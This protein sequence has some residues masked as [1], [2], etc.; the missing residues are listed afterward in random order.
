MAKKNWIKG[1]IKH[2]GALHEQLGVPADKKIPSKKMAS[3]RAGNYG[4]LAEKRAHLAKTLGSFDQ[5]GTV[6]KTGDYKLEEGEEVHSHSEG[7]GECRIMA[8]PDDVVRRKGRKR[9]DF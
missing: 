5:G 4:A 2:P 8:S 6:P 1:A 9:F 3:A 7:D